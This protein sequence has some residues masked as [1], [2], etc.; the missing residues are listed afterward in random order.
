V[1]VTGIVFRAV[2]NH[3]YVARCAN[4]GPSCFI[5]PYGRIIDKIVDDKGEELFVRGVL[6]N[7]VVPMD[8]KT[9]Y[10]RFGNWLVWLSLGWSGIFLG[11][12][13]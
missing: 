11:G 4:T 5:D 1:V 3:V 9:P 2:E 10:T 13:G 12:R 8:A 6:T 7:T